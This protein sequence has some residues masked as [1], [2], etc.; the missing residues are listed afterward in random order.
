MLLSAFRIGVFHRFCVPLEMVEK[1]IAFD[2]DKQITEDSIV[3][4]K[5]T[6]NFLINL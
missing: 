6:D 5:S 2:A 4:M 1:K 3:E